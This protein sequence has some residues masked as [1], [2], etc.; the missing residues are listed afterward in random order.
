M[1]PPEL[2]LIGPGYISQGYDP[3]QAAYIISKSSSD[4]LNPLSL[5]IDANKNSPLINPAFVITNWSKTD[6]VVKMNGNTLKKSIDYQIG[7]DKTFNGN[8]MIIWLEIE[9]DSIIN[10]RIE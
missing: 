7:Y 3:S 8:N 10:L 5:S 9:S 4:N 2:T 1:S 6:T